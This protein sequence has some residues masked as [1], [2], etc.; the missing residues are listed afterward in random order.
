MTFSVFKG[1]S[2]LKILKIICFILSK[3]ETQNARNCN[4]LTIDMLAVGTSRGAALKAESNMPVK[5]WC[6]LKTQH[7]DEV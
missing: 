3:K 6:D 1:N 7:Y 2:C 5:P 4:M